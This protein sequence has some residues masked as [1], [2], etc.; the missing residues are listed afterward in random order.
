MYEYEYSQLMIDMNAYAPIYKAV[1]YYSSVL[2]LA[3]PAFLVGSKLGLVGV[4]DAADVEVAFG[5]VGGECAFAFLGVQ[6][7]EVEVVDVDALQVQQSAQL[8]AVLLQSLLL[9]RLQSPRRVESLLFLLLP[10]LRRY[11]LGLVLAEGEKLLLLSFV[12][13][14][15]GVADVVE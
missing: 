7:V 1:R 6:R 11:G 14:V 13:V 10:S 15:H 5:V 3:A 8:E 12:D 2:F 4:D 9:P